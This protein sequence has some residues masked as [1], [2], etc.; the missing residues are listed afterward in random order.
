MSNSDAWKSN[1]R[2][3]FHVDEENRNDAIPLEGVQE[4]E[5]VEVASRDDDGVQQSSNRKKRGVREP[6]YVW[7][8]FTKITINGELKAKCNH[9]RAKLVAYDNNGT[10]HLDRHLKR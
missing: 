3:D 1:S 4:V 9:C 8:H 2:E 10:L 5:G 6:F 7:G